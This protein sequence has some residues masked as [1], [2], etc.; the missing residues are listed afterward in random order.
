[1]DKFTLDESY[2]IIP[3]A[4]ASNNYD[5]VGSGSSNTEMKSSSKSEFKHFCLKT[6]K[7][8]TEIFSEL[9][10]DTRK[11][12]TVCLCNECE[13]ELLK[14]IDDQHNILQDEVEAYEM[15]LVQLNNNMVSS[16]SDNIH[17]NS[18]QEQHH[19]NSEDN[20]DND[21][22]IF[23]KTLALS[24]QISLEEQIKSLNN[25]LNALQKQEQLHKLQL[26]SL[27]QEHIAVTITTEIELLVLNKL[28]FQKNN[29]QDDIYDLYNLLENSLHEIE[30]L[31]ND[32]SNT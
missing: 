21:D 27:Q 25:R 8:R 29:N 1:M 24:K 18:S 11:Y 10:N 9:L 3:S 28:E 15:G 2:F 31:N 17:V 32:N 16:E 23:V 14:Y 13:S 12:D 30:S 19:N 22:E 26:S 7:N 4:A 5:D 6:I 20:Y